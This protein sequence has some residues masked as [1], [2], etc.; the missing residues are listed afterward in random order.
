M[1]EDLASRLAAAAARVFV[2][3][4]V[5]FAY[6]FGSHALGAARADSDVDVAVALRPDVPGADHLDHLLD[7]GGRL[8]AELGGVEVDLVLLDEAPL[9]LRGRIVRDGVVIYSVDEP[10]R[11]EYESRTFREFADYS[12][13]VQPLVHQA[14]AD[15]AAGRR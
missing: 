4:P 14:L 9:P 10:A 12:I 5:R 3:A 13:W 6:L 11:V 1:D 2:G 8:Q 15:I 7:L